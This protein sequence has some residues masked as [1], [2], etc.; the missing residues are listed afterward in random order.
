MI[1]LGIFLS[2]QANDY[3]IEIGDEEG[4]VDSMHLRLLS[5]DLPHRVVPEDFSCLLGHSASQDDSPPIESISLART[6]SH[7]QTVSKQAQKRPSRQKSSQAKK[8]ARKS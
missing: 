8:K 2:L 3:N 5:A 4:A 1:S 7:Q 6:V